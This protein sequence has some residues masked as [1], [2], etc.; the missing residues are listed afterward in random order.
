MPVLP[1]DRD[2]E[3]RNSGVI[4]SPWWSKV[5][6]LVLIEFYLVTFSLF[7]H[8]PTDIAFLFLVHLKCL[9]LILELICCF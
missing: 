8:S 6:P 9:V 4:L 1:L 7:H 3:G 5:L 2:M